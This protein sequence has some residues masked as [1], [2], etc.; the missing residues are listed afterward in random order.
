MHRLFKLKHQISFFW[1]RIIASQ[2]KNTS[3]SM[4]TGS[5][6]WWLPLS[7]VNETWEMNYYLISVCGLIDKKYFKAWDLWRED[8]KVIWV[9]RIRK[10]DRKWL[11]QRLQRRRDPVKQD[12]E[13]C[14]GFIFPKVW[15]AP[16]ASA[17]PGNLL[18]IQILG[19]Y[20]LNRKLG[21]RS[22]HLCSNGP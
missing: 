12:C 3:Y 1:A 15:S 9:K 8:N 10:M 4:L 7:L 19:P 16:T 18:E 22:S 5:S 20:L 2:Y 14:A 13:R 11:G 21:M 6:D 17:P